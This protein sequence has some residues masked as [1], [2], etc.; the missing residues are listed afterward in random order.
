MNIFALDNC[1]IQ[2]AKWHCDRHVVKMILEGTQL[3]CTAYHM[4][5]VDAPYKKT[6][7]NHP[8]AI[9]TRSSLNNFKWTLQYVYGLC[10]EYYERYLKTHKTLLVAYWCEDNMDR[11]TFDKTDLT[12]F[13]LA[14]PDEYKVSDPVESYRNYYRL[15]KQHLHNWKQ[16]KPE[17][18]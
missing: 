8:C 15:G 11:L 9:W 1:P 3:L 12:P 7:I 10:E 4:Q 18:L 5:G 2:S 6:H 13:A 14:M 17:W 16:N